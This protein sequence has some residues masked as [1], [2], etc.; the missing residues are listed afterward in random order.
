MDMEQAACTSVDPD[1]FF[2][3]GKNKREQEYNAK[4]I[5]GSCPI[6]TDCLQFAIDNEQMGI[7]G[8]TTEEERRY[9]NVIIK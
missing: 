8:G 4:Q 6:V 3:E 7:W 5:C 2:P 9:I 1:L